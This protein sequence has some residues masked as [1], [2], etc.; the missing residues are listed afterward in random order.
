MNLKTYLFCLNEDI[1]IKE[2]ENLDED[3]EVVDEGAFQFASK[4]LASNAKLRELI[5]K[6]PAIYT[7]IRTA[8]RG[9]R[10]MSLDAAEEVAARRFLGII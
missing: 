1:D 2:I 9:M 3:E 4:R 8:A 6:D 10:G 7:K 5:S